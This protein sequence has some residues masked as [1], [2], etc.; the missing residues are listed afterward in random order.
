MAKNKPFSSDNIFKSFWKF[1]LLNLGIVL[2]LSLFQCPSCFFSWE[3]FISNR[4]QFI[5]S[6]L[7]SSSLSFGGYWVDRFYESKISWIKEP[8]KR[9]LATV[10]TYM[11]Y[12]FIVSFIL[13]TGMVLI[14]VEEVNIYNISWI[15]M[16][17]NTIMPTIIA[18]IIISI[19]ISRGWL[20]EWRNAAIEAEK[21]RTEK[22]ASQYQSLKDQL[23]PHFL[24]NSLNVLSNL[25]YES[26]DKS[27]DFIQQLSRI[28]RYV[29]EVQNEELA[30]LQDE[31]VFAENY[32]S[33]QKIRFEESLEYFMDI[34]DAAGFYIPPLSLQLLLENAIKHNVA[35]KK[36]PLKIFISKKADQLE[37]RNILQPK[38]VKESPSSGIGLENIQKRYKLLSGKTPE[39]EDTGKEFIVSLPL[40]KIE[41]SQ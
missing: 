10:I 14:L 21:L 22:F 41:R 28:Y 36:Q 32:L 35:S 25:V 27:A 24:F 37:V 19:F 39:V 2:V 11:L 1:I 13:I 29:L 38:S 15:R 30:S 7:M 33:L 40:L 20:M 12:S 18:F 26:A 4:N 23:N 5:F 17:E 6:F 34:D 9:F 3:I 8:L 31:L 16:V